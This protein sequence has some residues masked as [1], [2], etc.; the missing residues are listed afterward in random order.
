MLFP[1][2]SASPGELT[3]L[4]PS[5]GDDNITLFQGELGL[6][7]GELSQLRESGVI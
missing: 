1:G 6:S 4:G 2:L 5:L 7:D 3:T